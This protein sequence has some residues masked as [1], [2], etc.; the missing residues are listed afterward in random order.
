MLA[1]EGETRRKSALS[2]LSPTPPL[3]RSPAPLLALFLAFALSAWFFVPAMV[4]KTAV[5]LGTVTEGYFH[6]SN[7]F[8]TTDL[9][10]TTLFYHDLSE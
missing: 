6:F 4:E 2:G 3:P 5:Q 9:V 8:R 1:A 7:H 10:Q